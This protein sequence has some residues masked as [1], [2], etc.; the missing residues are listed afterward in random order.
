MLRNIK[1]IS[2]NKLDLCAGDGEIFWNIQDSIIKADKEQQAKFV[3]MKT[4]YPDFWSYCCAQ[5]EAECWKTNSCDPDCTRKVQ[6]RAQFN[7][8]LK[9]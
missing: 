8:S 3:R 5:K 7:C 1:V 9:I 2:N 6:G 4:G